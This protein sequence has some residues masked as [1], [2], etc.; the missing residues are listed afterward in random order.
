[1][2]MNA[3]KIFS[4]FDDG[5]G[6][7][8]DFDHNKDLSYLLEDYRKHPMFWVGMFK[9]LIHNHKIFNHKVMDFF[10]D[11]D[12]ELDIYDVETAG[13]FVVYNRAWFWISKIDISDRNHQKSL[14]HFSDEYLDTY[15]KFSISYWEETEEFEKCAHLKHILDF[16][17]EPL[18]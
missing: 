4:L 11:M 2:Y 17:K 1:M 18:I 6:S 3:D 12:E 8:P 7:K 16:L 15:L 14:V 10:T 9:K 5:E 13:E